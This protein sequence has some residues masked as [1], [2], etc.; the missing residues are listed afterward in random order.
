MEGGKEIQLGTW[1]KSYIVDFFLAYS[2]CKGGTAIN[3]GLFRKDRCKY[4]TTCADAECQ[5]EEDEC[6]DNAPLTTECIK[7]KSFSFGVG[8]NEHS[9]LHV[10]NGKDKTLGYHFPSVVMRRQDTI[11]IYMPKSDEWDYRKEYKL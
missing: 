11:G 3:G 5:L 9:I 2:V 8:A 10:T 6:K 7:E 1:G 4:V